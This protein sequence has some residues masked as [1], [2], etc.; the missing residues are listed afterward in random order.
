MK[1]K[2]TFYRLSNVFSF[3]FLLADLLRQFLIF[4]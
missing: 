3:S 2:K 4:L 1:T